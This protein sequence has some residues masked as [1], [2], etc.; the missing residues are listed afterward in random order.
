[1]VYKE[2]LINQTISYFQAPL[3][4]FNSESL[5]NI[6]W[7][8]EEVDV[9]GCN[10]KNYFPISNKESDNFTFSLS[11]ILSIEDSTANDYKN[12][13]NIPN[14]LLGFFIK[15]E[16]NQFIYKDINSDLP[17]FKYSNIRN[18][19]ILKIEKTESITRI[20]I[21]FVTL[22]PNY[23]SIYIENISQNLYFLQKYYKSFSENTYA[24]FLFYYEYDNKLTQD[25]LT[26][27]P[28]DANRIIQDSK[29]INF[30]LK[31]LP[32]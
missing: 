8:T 22:F 28:Q 6:S 2:N 30:S 4:L 13:E 24:T 19:S 21:E 16:N 14:N 10:F 23:N 9:F 18:A 26:S 12:S 15:N 20:Y 27:N 11:K 29:L 25:Y 3:Y 32:Q 7:P 17:Y 31:L 5:S 1:M